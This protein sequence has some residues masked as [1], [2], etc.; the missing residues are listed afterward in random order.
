MRW[1]LF[2]EF[3]LTVAIVF[4]VAGDLFLP[5]PYRSGSQQLKVNLNQF[6]TSLLPRKTIIDFAP[7]IPP[8]S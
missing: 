6:L 7:K 2:F 3:C 8:H 5:Q 1:K 4:I